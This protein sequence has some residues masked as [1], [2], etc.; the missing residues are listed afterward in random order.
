MRE[1]QFRAFDKY[2]KRLSYVREIK[3]QGGK[4][5]KVRLGVDSVLEGKSIDLLMQ[6]TGFKDTNGVDI[7]EGDIVQDELGNIGEITHH[8]SSFYCEFKGCGAEYLDEYPAETFK[9]IGNIYENKE[10]L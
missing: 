5:H 10:L 8:K 2:M 1:I 7:Y 6:N 4:I 9:V 3:F